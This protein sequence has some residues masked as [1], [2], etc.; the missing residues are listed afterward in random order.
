VADL[1]GT[2]FSIM[3]FEAHG[4]FKSA[5]TSSFLHNNDNLI[6]STDFI[7]LN[8]IHVKFMATMQS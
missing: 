7:D 3:G 1:W 6:H 5:P 2:T 8:V 4:S